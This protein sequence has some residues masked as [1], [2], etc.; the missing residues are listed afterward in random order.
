MSMHFPSARQAI[1]LLALS[2]SL[3]LGTDCSWGDEPIDPF[4][5]LEE[6]SGDKTLAWVKER[7]AACT[8]ELTKGPEFAAL[9]A[10]LLKNLDSRD[11]IPSISKN[12]QHGAHCSIPM[13]CRA[14]EFSGCNWSNSCNTSLAR[15]LSLRS[16]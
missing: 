12:G 1:L 11:Q 8:A 5:W 14:L 15:G 16:A 3:S 6:V 10:R 7:N 4:R 2:F 9:N 13:A